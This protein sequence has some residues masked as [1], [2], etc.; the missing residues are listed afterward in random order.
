MP[1]YKLQLTLFFDDLGKELELLHILFEK[2][3]WQQKYRETV[4]QF[5]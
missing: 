2:K 3:V 4:Q 1:P 5:V